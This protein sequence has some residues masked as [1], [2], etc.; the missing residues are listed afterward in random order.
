M[1][2]IAFLSILCAGL[3][4]Q[5]STHAQILKKLGDK[6]KNKVEQRADR[7]VDNAMEKGL[8]EVEGKNKTKTDKDGDTKTKSEDGTKTKTDAD[9]DTKVKSPEGDK[10]KTQLAFNSKYDFVPGEKLIAYEDFSNAE[11]GDFPTRW[12]TNAT[13]EVVTINNKEGKW[14]KIQKGGVFHPEFITDLPQNF[15]IEFDLGINDNWNSEEF[16]I[17][18][19]NLEKATD[20]TDFSYYINWKHGHAVHLQFHPTTLATGWSRILVGSTGNHTVNNTVEFK[21]WDPKVTNF[22]HVAIWRQN[23]RLRVYINGEKIWDIPRAFDAASKYN[24]VTIARQGSYKTDDYYLFGNFRMAAGAPDTRNKLIT[25]GKFV[26]RGIL[27]DVNSDKIRPESSGA[28]K[29][30]GTILKDNAT[31]KVKIIGHTDADGD[32]KANMDLSKRRAEAVK[33][34]LAKEYGISAENMET[35]GK[36]E[37]APLDKNTTAEGKANNRRVEF[38]KM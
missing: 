24:T 28:L 9:G 29:E 14:L 34:Y 18:M 12:N 32:D 11:I 15:T 26:T 37:S 25:E 20:F 17:N 30:I 4:I 3:L 31:V 1:K 13:A 7:K 27:F 33:D 22:A 5:N 36:G 16:V 21:V 6:A 2:K 19:G 8:D 35:D 23:Q 10:T 38:I